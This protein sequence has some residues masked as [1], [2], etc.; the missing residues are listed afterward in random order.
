MGSQAKVL[1]KKRRT[2]A[3]LGDCLFLSKLCLV[4]I[5]GLQP[6]WRV[7]SAKYIKFIILRFVYF[8]LS[9]C[10]HISSLLILRSERNHCLSYHHALRS[11]LPILGTALRASGATLHSFAT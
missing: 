6:Y 2:C 4:S 11:I 7:G 5:F 8:F 9:S 10:L 3:S 1:M